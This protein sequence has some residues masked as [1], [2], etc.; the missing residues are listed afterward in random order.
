MNGAQQ[1]SSMSIVWYTIM[2]Q[3]Y[4]MY[5]KLPLKSNRYLH[6][7]IF[8]NLFNYSWTLDSRNIKFIQNCGCLIYTANQKKPSICNMYVLIEFLTAHRSCK[9]A[10]F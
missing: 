4:S 7:S 1:L 6:I 8:L 3:Y 2:K 9:T 10:Y 5:L